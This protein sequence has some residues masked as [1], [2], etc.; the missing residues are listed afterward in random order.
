MAIMKALESAGADM[1]IS[2]SEVSVSRSQLKAF[3]FDATYSPDL[4]PPLAALA[5]Y[6][7]GVSNIKGVSRLIHKESDR[8]KTLQQELGRM[9]IHITINDDVMSILGGQPDGGKVESHGDHRV[10]MATAIAALRAKNTVYLRDSHAVSK[11]YPA[12]YKDIA[13]LGA[14]VH[15]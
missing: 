10:A 1:K 3:D 14:I 12:F 6:C 5:A 8:A 9:N 7:N 4:F 15:E 13:A 2:G 11:S